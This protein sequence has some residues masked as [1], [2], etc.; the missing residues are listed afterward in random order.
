MISRVY[1]AKNKLGDEGVNKIAEA[2]I[3]TRNLIVLDLSNNSITHKGCKI[4]CEALGWN[5]SL[6]DLNL[7]SNEGPHKNILGPKG[8]FAIKNFFIK[9]S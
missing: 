8:A 1:L 9:Q 7:S 6:I 4:F 2:L 3:R 5:E